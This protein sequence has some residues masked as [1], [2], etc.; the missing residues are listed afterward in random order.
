VL[1]PVRRALGYVAQYPCYRTFS[2]LS[3]KQEPTLKL[4]MLRAL[5]SALPALRHGPLLHPDLGHRLFGDR[6][7]RMLALQKVRAD[8]RNWDWYPAKF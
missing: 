5:A 2:A 3:G 1:P 6:T 4:R 7:V 8:T